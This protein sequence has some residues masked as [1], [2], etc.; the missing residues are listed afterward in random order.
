MNFLQNDQI[1]EPRTIYYITSPIY[2]YFLANGQCGVAPS[3]LL[4]P[5]RLLVFP[6]HL[7]MALDVFPRPHVTSRSHGLSQHRLVR[8]M[9]PGHGK[10]KVQPKYTHRVNI[11]AFVFCIFIRVVQFPQKQS[12]CILYSIHSMH[13]SITHR[14]QSPVL[15]TPSYH[16]SLQL[17]GL[18]SD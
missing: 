15:Y 17:K 9:P 16:N 3:Q 13:D 11:S 6:T 5:V 7:A 12:D 14:Q 2:L 18:K 4:L 10:W 1:L 8:K